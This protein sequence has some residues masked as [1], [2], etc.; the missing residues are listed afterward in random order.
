MAVGRNATPLI[1]LDAVALDT[2]TTGLDP[3][4]ARIVEIG[5]VRLLGGRLDSSAPFWSLVQP[6]EP[7]PA[8][9]T[10]IHGIDDSK[11]AAAPPFADIWPKFSTY[12]GAAVVIGHTLSFD[13]TVLK[14]ECERVGET[15]R[16][17]SALDVRLLAQFA[18]PNLADYSLESLAAWLG[19]EISGRHSALGDATAAGLIF[20]A[21]VPRLR[22]RGIRTL[23]EATRSAQLLADSLHEPPSATWHQL[24]AT[25]A[26]K[27]TERPSTRADT[28]LY[29]HRV[30]DVMTA[31]AQ[32]VAPST[33]IGSA[34]ERLTREQI[35]SLFVVPDPTNEPARPENSGIVTERDILRA[36]D[37]HGAA[38]MT[39]SVEQVASRPLSAVAARALAYQAIARMNRLRVRHLGVIDDAGNLVGALSARDLLRL[40]AEDAAE[41]G[42]EIDQ[43]K[44][45]HELARA[46]AKLAHV[47][48]ALVNEG[49]AGRE[50]AAVISHEI[51]ELTRRAAVLGESL[52]AANG[53]GSAPCAYAFMVLGSAGRNESLLAMDQDSALVFTD[54]AP[55][56]A[57]G[58]FET[59]AIHTTRILHE[60]G[61]PFCKGGV[62]AK[63]PQWRGSFSTWRGRIGDWISRSS[64]QDLLSVD[65][66]FD[67]RGVHG[68][69]ELANALRRHAFEA[70][71]G[72]ADFAKLLVEAGGAVQPS[73]TW[74]GGIRTDNG[75]IDLKRSGLFG[76]VSSVRALAICLGV[77]ERSTPE[78]L[79]G[80]KALRASSDSNLDALVDAHGVF[81]DLI[82]RQQIIDIERGQ[83]ASN[84]VEMKRLSRRE[85]ERLRTALH[86]V[87]HVSE[88]T[89]DLVFSA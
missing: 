73:R 33:L 4:K 7:I 27:T 79:N 40:R 86:A 5:A 51:G 67:I 76:V 60:V 82:L 10:R 6:G 65:I 36:L 81:L 13:L 58:W 63:N 8:T 78:R 47:S 74:F 37:A 62:M 85:R 30:A 72:R 49:L 1:A 64:S 21:L 55:E 69:I 88:L 66:F 83:P 53:Q 87:E 70:A 57:D 15:V 18:E 29:R 71:C 84:S 35:S 16:V 34:L 89:R 22:D 23:G 41:L 20:C 42:D 31:P 19:V 56:G 44:D 26:D 12:V 45:V 11:V 3:R 77:A 43:A 28:Y 61:V 17:P 24:S 59:L 68:N 14:R 48:A 54:D 39:L 52:M 75:R 25:V 2:E 50:I 32:S 9:A 46:W 80:I 38:A